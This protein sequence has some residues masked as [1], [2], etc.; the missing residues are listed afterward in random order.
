MGDK[1]QKDKNKGLK[2]KA[3]KEAKRTRENGIDKREHQVSLRSIDRTEPS[4]C[5][6][7]PLF[8]AGLSAVMP[9][10]GQAL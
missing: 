7:T 6:R 4:A 2:Q 8:A 5:T 10:L 9:G 1:G 3:A